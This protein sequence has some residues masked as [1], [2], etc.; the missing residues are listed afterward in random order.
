MALE[1]L[2]NNIHLLPPSA[3]KGNSTDLTCVGHVTANIFSELIK[4]KD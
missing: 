3:N 2:N 1:S 4:T